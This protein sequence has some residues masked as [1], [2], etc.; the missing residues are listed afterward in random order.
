MTQRT[1]GFRKKSR[2]KLRK[3]PRN[4]GKVNINQA[5]QTFKKN[6]KVRIIQEPAIHNAMPMPKYKNKVGTVIGKQGTAYIL[7]VKDFKKKK[8]LLS[9]AIHLRKIN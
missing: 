9:D 8:R 7:E 5:L 6:D 1:G 3:T 2:H 4:R